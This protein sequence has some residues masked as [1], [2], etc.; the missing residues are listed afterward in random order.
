MTKPSEKQQYQADLLDWRRKHFGELETNMA[1]L[2]ELRDKKD[3]PPK[4]RIEAA[5]AIARHLSGLQSERPSSKFSGGTADTGQEKTFPLSE[6][7][8]AALDKLLSEAHGPT[9]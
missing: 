8:R 5:K 6:E 7:E 4:E 3:V 1:V 9:N 2:K